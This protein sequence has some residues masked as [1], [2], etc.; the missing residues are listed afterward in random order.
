MEIIPQSATPGAEVRAL[1]LSA[2]LDDAQFERLNQAFLDY[3]ILFFRDQQ[4][5]SQQY[6]NTDFAAAESLV[7]WLDPGALQRGQ[8]PGRLLA[9]QPAYPRARPSDNCRCVMPIASA[10]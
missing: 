4:L 8:R 10:Q 5:T 9:S 1:D 2:A 7:A 3:Q 6:T